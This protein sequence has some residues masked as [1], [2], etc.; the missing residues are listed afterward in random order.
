MMSAERGAA[1]NT[2]DAYARDILAFAIDC[3]RGGC[4]L[5]TADR[6]Q[7]RAHLA[8]LSAA[9]IKPSSQARKL[10]ALR[11]FFGFLYSE[12]IRRDDPCGAVEAPRLSR[13]LPKILSAAEALR[14]VEAARQGADDNPERARL[15][16]HCRD[17]LRLGASHQ[18]ARRPCRL[19]AV[20]AK[21]RMIHVRGKGG[22]E[23]LA[24]VGDEA[25]QALEAYLLVRDAFLPR[26]RLGV[27]AARY[28]F[29][30]RG[31]ESHLTR[32]RCH[33]MLKSLAAEAG[34]APARLSPHV[35]R[36]AFATHLV[37]GGA[38]LTERSDLLG[39]RRYRDDANLYPCGGRP[40]ETHD[41]IGPSA[42]ACAFRASR[43]GE[44]P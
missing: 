16:L 19:A 33:Q 29:P 3:A 22:R 44:K 43:V 41:G 24:P 31:A 35:L 36:H 18:R 23:R 11:R 32:R 13:P 39:P 7:V 14:L 6:E 38:D 34:I 1:Q 15:R 2:L 12:G 4:D 8:G 40:V 37:E 9:S 21:E 10:S 42:G 17:A 5:K 25:R 30:S 27:A 28:L 26:G 20:R